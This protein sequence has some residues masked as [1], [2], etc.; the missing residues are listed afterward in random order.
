VRRARPSHPAR[1]IHRLLACERSP[2]PGAHFDDDQ[3][4]AVE[5]VIEI[6]RRLK[7]RKHGKRHGPKERFAPFCIRS[8]PPPRRAADTRLPVAARAAPSGQGT[9][10]LI[11][12]QVLRMRSEGTSRCV[13]QGGG[14]RA[15]KARLFPTAAPS[16]TRR[17]PLV[18][19][20]ARRGLDR[21]SYPRKATA[22]QMAAQTPSDRSDTMVKDAPSDH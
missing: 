4:P 6:P 8:L 1:R 14:A 19:E 13:S 18:R 20:R 22:C 3:R 9:R 7:K 15:V 16:A 10:P 5:Q 21:E 17:R 12:R 11:A 2:N